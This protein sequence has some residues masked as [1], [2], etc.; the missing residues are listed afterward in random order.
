[1]SFSSVER[2]F[3]WHSR[4][5]CMPAV[6][7]AIRNIDLVTSG[8]LTGTYYYCVVSKNPVKYYTAES[9]YENKSSGRYYKDSNGL[10]VPHYTFSQSPASEDVKIQWW[11][12]F[13]GSDSSYVYRATDAN[14]TQNLKR[15]EVSNGV[16]IDNLT[17]VYTEFTDDDTGWSDTSITPTFSLPSSHWQSV[18]ISDPDKNYEINDITLEG[19]N[20]STLSSSLSLVITDENDNILKTLFAEDLIG[21]LSVNFLK[22]STFY[23]QSETNSLVIFSNDWTE[24]SPAD[25]GVLSIFGNNDLAD[26]VYLS[27]FTFA[28]TNITTDFGG[29]IIIETSDD[30]GLTWSSY[31]TLTNWNDFAVIA[32]R[33]MTGAWKTLNY[34]I[35]THTPTHPIEVRSNINRRIRIRRSAQLTGS[36]EIFVGAEGKVSYINNPYKVTKMNMIDKDNPLVLSGG[37]KLKL[38]VPANTHLAGSYL[39]MNIS[40]HYIE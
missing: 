31:I 4:H 28:I 9:G 40:G 35:F 8:S 3:N 33:Q 21:G 12:I 10:T 37:K 23:Q 24:A 32:D 17:R 1:M 39:W 11:N 14:F 25:S 2:R 7:P 38:Y 6:A 29:T 34:I 19:G 30:N 16:L 27:E 13:G 36:S 15:Q 5:F 20:F 18:F 26:V 22:E